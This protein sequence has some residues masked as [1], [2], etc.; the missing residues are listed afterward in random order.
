LTY[1]TCDHPDW[2]ICLWLSGNAVIQCIFSSQGR[3]TTDEDSQQ[4]GVW[5]ILRQQDHGRFEW[6]V[7]SCCRIIDCSRDIGKLFYCLECTL[8]QNSS[9]VI[10]GYEYTRRQNCE[11]RVNII[12]ISAIDEAIRST[13]TV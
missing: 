10:V 8:I 5:C 9:L 11:E 13:I 1:H 12:R 3:A 2:V 4:V 6:I 7:A